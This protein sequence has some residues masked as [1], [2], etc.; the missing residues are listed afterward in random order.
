MTNKEKAVEIASQYGNDTFIVQA[1][2]DMANWKDLRFNYHE[3]MH[4]IAVKYNMTNKEFRELL[5]TMPDDALVCIEC[6]HPRAM[7]YDKKYNLIRID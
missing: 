5:E 7:V 6:C 2:L 1:A 4:Y 3:R